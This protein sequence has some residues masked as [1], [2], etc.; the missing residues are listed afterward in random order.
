[1]PPP[2]LDDSIRPDRLDV[3]SNSGSIRGGWG[4]GAVLVHVGSPRP[5]GEE[6]PLVWEDGA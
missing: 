1:M 2:T 5:E 6:P 4:V 3:A